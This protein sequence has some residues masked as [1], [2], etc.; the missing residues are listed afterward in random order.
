M[1][2]AAAFREESGALFLEEDT[3]MKKATWKGKP[4][5]LSTSILLAMAAFTVLILNLQYSP[6]NVSAHSG[7]V[8]GPACGAAI[9]DGKINAAEW[10]NASKKT[11]QMFSPSAAE[12]F[13]ATL[14]VM[15][16]AHY[17]YLGITINDDEL[18][19]VGEFLP[20]GDG[21]RIDFDNDHGGTLFELGD[22]VLGI[23]A[24]FPQF[25]DAYLF[26][27]ATQ[28]ARS[29]IESGGTS[30]GAGAANRAGG[31]NHF[32]LRHPLCSG[33]SLDFCLHPTDTVGFRL[34]YLD[35]QANGSFGGSQ[36][37]PGSGNTDEA[38]IVIGQC[39]S[40]RDWF[41]YLPLIRKQ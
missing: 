33:D 12:P 38:D 17:L 41:F 34:E 36:L 21:F 22:D 25:T 39:S 8:F 10:A 4:I 9:V 5:W 15:N 16:G 20:D 18:S 37:F 31:L 1:A 28:S 13:T 35:A 32:E 24:G 40:I 14:Y 3:V 19:T 29:D 7:D 23:H 26:V 27:P 11:F 30:D 2:A 6:M